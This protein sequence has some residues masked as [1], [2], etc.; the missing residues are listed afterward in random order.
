MSP[1]AL[2]PVPA[3]YV[4]LAFVLDSLNPQPVGVV[5]D[6]PLNARVLKFS[7]TVLPRLVML[8]G[9]EVSADT[10]RTHT[11]STTKG[12]ANLRIGKLY[13]SYCDLRAMNA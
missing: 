3:V 9:V 7:L 10:P 1:V 12:I 8:I 2:E 11:A 6:V 4:V 5:D 13:G